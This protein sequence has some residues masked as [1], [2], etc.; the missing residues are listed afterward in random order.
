MSAAKWSA[1]VDAAIKYAPKRLHADREA[2]GQIRAI[3]EQA[4]AERSELLEALQRCKFDSLNMTLADLE[5]C[6]AAIAKATGAAS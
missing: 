6:R 1:K 2:F 3:A 5:F 4:D